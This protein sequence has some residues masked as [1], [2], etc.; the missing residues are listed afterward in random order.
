MSG[1]VEAHKV[2]GKWRAA[3]ELAKTHCPEGHAY[4]DENTYLTG[5]G[6]RQC[7]ECKRAAVRRYAAR[8]RERIAAKTR[9]WR[10]RTG[11]R[12]K[13]RTAGHPYTPENTHITPSGKRFC[14]AC[15][16]ERSAAA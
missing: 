16:I 5:R 9:D 14:I 11:P 1:F 3:Y 12:D 8:N 10:S 13:C 4:D 15:R 2:T 7:R 6:H